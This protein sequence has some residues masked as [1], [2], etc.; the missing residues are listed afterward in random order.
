MIVLVYYNV[1]SY[2]YKALS[3]MG[4]YCNLKPKT[5]LIIFIEGF[6]KMRHNLNMIQ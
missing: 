3:Q 2:D 1:K 6:V 4:E 5:S